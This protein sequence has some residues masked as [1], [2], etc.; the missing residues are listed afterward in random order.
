MYQA[1]L[2]SLHYITRLIQPPRSCVWGNDL[3]CFKR[4]IKWNGLHNRRFPVTY[5]D[6]Q[7]Q[8]L[9]H[10]SIW[11]KLKGENMRDSLFMYL[12]NLSSQNK[13]FTKCKVCWWFVRQSTVLLFHYSSSCG[14]LAWLQICSTQ[15]GLIIPS[16]I[17]WGKVQESCHENAGIRRL[18]QSAGY[19]KHRD[20]NKWDLINWL[21]VKNIY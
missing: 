8:I 3:T 18:S 15:S 17:G 9:I 14:V 5:S 2:V 21:K 12:Y 1:D 6:L 4:Q 11:C 16:L 20:L 19:W 10:T 13:H 7:Q